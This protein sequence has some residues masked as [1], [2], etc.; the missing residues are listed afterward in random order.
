[1]KKILAFA[2]VAL[3]SAS[4]CRLTPCDLSCEYQHSPLVDTA[5]PHL[6]WKNEASRNGAEQTAWQIVVCKGE[7]VR[8]GELAWDSGKVSSTESAH[9][10][11]AGEPLI[12]ASDYVWQVRVWDEQGRAS[13]WSSPNRFHTGK[14]SPEEWQ[15]EWI[16]APWQGDDSYDIEAAKGGNTRPKLDPER[17]KDVHPAPLLRKEFEVSKSV[18]SARFY[19]TGLGY[20]ELYINGQRVGEDYLVPNQTNYDRRPMLDTRGIAVCDPFEEYTVMYLSYDVKPLLERGENV[21]GAILGNGFYDV[22]EYWPPMGYGSPRLFGQIE[23]EY[24]DGDREVIA[25]D[26]TWRCSRSAIVADQ[27]FLGEHYDARLEQ[28]GWAERGFDDSSWECVALKRAP[29]G[30]LIA[31]NAPADRI[32]E[33]IAPKSIVKQEDGSW[34]VSFPEEISGWVNLEN[35]DLA[36]GQKVDIKYLCESLNGANSYTAKGSGKESYHARFVWFVFSEVEIRGVDK[37]S[38]RQ[39]EA[40]AVNTDV[41]SVSEFSSSNELLNKIHRAWRRTQLDNM[42][43]GVASDCPQ[44]ERSPYTGDGQVACVAVMQNFDAAAFYNKWIRDIRGAQTEDGYVPNSAPW[45]PGCGGGPAWGAAVAIM[46]WEHYMHYGDERILAENYEAMKRYVEW[47]GRWV[48]KDGVMLAADAQKWKNLGDWVAPR[49]NPPLEVVHTFY[50]WMCA[51]IVAQSAEVLGFA[52]DA[53]AHRALAERTREAFHAR[54]YNPET[55]SYGKHGCNVFALKMGLPEPF[56]TDAVEAL[57][58]NIAEVD[59][60]LDTGIFGTRYLFEVLCESGEEDLAY[61]IIN[62]R[63]FPSFGHWIEQG[64]TTTWEQWNGKNSRNHPMWGGGIVWFY[65]HLAGLKPIEAGYR[66]F[67]IA[68]TVPDGLEQ[69]NYSIDTTYGEISVAWRVEGGVLT[70]ECGVPVGTRA[71]IA[72][73]GA[74]E[75]IE[76]G[77]GQYKFSQKL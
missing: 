18:R 8:G 69:V 63:T 66:T 62:K 47:M 14:F 37:L 61:S 31:Q 17:I 65:T 10:V 32:T 1:M 6:A 19:G 74:A 7:S 42:H 51:D 5:T 24:C 60:H 77:A 2:M 68:P 16:G 40:H 52:D 22:V 53:A 13:R 67:E 3:F 28:E 54:F 30:T 39:I 64:A 26:T 72:L 75:S 56:R 44:R 11:Y 21:V 34:L 4:C 76:V 41:E 23:I 25:T 27:M 57:K 49:K 12:S 15:A 38:A 48:D 33:R 71:K 55:K 45:Q 9:I 70:L 35:L 46:P 29:C 43:G 59:G 20:F 73:P 58:S 36:E 50:Y